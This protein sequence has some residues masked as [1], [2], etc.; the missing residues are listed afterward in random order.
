MLHADELYDTA[1]ANNVNPELVVITAKGEGN[2]EESGGSYNYW[3]LGCPNGSASGYSYGSFA[4]GVAD[5]ARVIGY[6]CEGGQN[7]AIIMQR[8]EERADTGCDPLGYGLPGTLGGMQSVYSWLGDTHAVNSPGAGGMYYL[9]PWGWGG[10]WYEGKN[11]IIFESKEEFEEKCGSQHGT[12]GGRLSDT[13][14][15]AWEQGQYTAWQAK[16]KVRFWNDIFG[17][18]GSL[19]SGAS[20][21]DNAKKNTTSNSSKS[22]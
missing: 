4:E 16:S 8:Y 15:T 21:K 6:C 1:V 11:K 20:D 19:D 2:F 13:P 10:T 7:E 22:K 5:Y 17:E 3:G 12:S 14:T 18:Y 9:Y